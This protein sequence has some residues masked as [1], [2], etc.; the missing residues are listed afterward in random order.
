VTFLKKF[1]LFFFAQDEMSFQDAATDRAVLL[2]SHTALQSSIVRSKKRVSE[3][4]PGFGKVRQPAR[5]VALLFAYNFF[6]A[7][8]L[9]AQREVAGL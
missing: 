5:P 6:R 8:A 7:S 3:T 9:R 4:A 2:R 1:L